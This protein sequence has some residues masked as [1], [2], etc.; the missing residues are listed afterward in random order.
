MAGSLEESTDGLQTLD[1]VRLVAVRPPPLLLQHEGQGKV[2]ALIEAVAACFEDPE[3]GARD[4]L[5]W[6]S[7]VTFAAFQNFVITPGLDAFCRAYGLIWH[8]L[9]LPRSGSSGPVWNTGAPVWRRRSSKLPMTAA[10][11]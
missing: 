2:E 10:H 1:V 8:R 6:G 11:R 3:I 4:A 9:R 5:A 7:S